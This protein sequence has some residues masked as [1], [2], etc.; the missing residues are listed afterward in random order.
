MIAAAAMSSTPKQPDF[1]RFISIHWK[2]DFQAV[3]PAAKSWK[4]ATM[5]C[6]GMVQLAAW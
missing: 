2:R 1:D 3:P 4:V 5:S 6:K